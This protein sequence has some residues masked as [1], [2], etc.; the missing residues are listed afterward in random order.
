MVDM[1]QLEKVKTKS[2]IESDQARSSAISYLSS[3]DW[4][5]I[6]QLETGQEVPQ[7]VSEARAEARSKL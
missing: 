7:D 6:R 4:Y 2:E 1:T 3:T 5:V